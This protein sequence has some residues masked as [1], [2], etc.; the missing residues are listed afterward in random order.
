METVIRTQL[1]TSGERQGVYIP[2][3]IIE[4]FNFQNDIQ[5]EVLADR[6]IIHRAPPP[7]A[8]WDEQF[9]AMA[10]A[11]D[12]QLLDAEALPLTKWDETEWS[13]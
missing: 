7:R 2:Q 10:Q 6:L 13:W 1:I 5:L 12:D 4:Q 3:S 11:G 8:G 9:A